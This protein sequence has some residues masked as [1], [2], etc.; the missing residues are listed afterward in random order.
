M[1]DVEEVLDDAWAQR[2]EAIRPGEKSA[3]ARVLGD[4]KVENWAAGIGHRD[5]DRAVALLNWID[6]SVSL[7]RRRQ[8]R[9]RGKA[10]TLAGWRI[11]PRMVRTDE[12]VAGGYG[13]RGR[14]TRHDR[15]G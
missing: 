11:L 3:E 2:A 9:L 5:P 6:L 12:T 14:R 7:V 1:G 10:N 15:R 4:G 13:I 8:L